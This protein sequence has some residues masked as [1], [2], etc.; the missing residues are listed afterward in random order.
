MMEKKM[1]TIIM[2]SIGFRVSGLDRDNGKEDGNYYSILLD[3]CSFAYLSVPRN[4]L[5]K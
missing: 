2:G 4:R 3:L 5:L 1:G